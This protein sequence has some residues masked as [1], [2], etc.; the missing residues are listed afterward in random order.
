MLLLAAVVAFGAA[1]GGEAPKQNKP[2]F[3]NLVQTEEASSVNG[4]NLSKQTFA[5]LLDESAVAQAP[6]QV[7]PDTIQISLDQIE[8]NGQ[9]HSLPIGVNSREIRSSSRDIK[10]PDE[11]M[12][13]DVDQAIAAI[14]KK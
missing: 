13:D 6:A 5:S 7:T 10:N 8:I 11:E 14:R 4:K 12:C 2:T 9:V 3:A 1:C